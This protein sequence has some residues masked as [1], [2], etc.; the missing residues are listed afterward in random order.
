[1]SCVISTPKCSFS[2]PSASLLTWTECTQPHTTMSLNIPSSN[3][4]Q[5]PTSWPPKA[6][7]QGTCGSSSPWSVLT[8]AHS[9]CPC[10]I[11]LLGAVQHL[12]QGKL[13]TDT[14]CAEIQTM[15]ERCQEAEDMYKN[16]PGDATT[17][18]RWLFWAQSGLHWCFNIGGDL[19]VNARKCWVRRNASIITYAARWKGLR[20]WTFNRKDCSCDDVWFICVSQN[21]RP[22][23]CALCFFSISRLEI[24]CAANQIQIISYAGDGKSNISGTM[25]KFLSEIQMYLSQM[26]QWS[27]LLYLLKRILKTSN[28]CS[29][30]TSV[31][32]NDRPPKNGCLSTM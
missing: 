17:K 9:S 28:Q 21:C 4:I 11:G 31:I 3:I 15:K 32:K 6:S 7:G 19:M 24:L 8:S 18:M 30:C 25:N 13:A 20:T 26:V 1:M 23:L 22:N 16:K 12:Q 27:P 10:V 2:N 5:H 14:S 29:F